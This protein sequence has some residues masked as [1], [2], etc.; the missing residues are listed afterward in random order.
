MKREQWM[1]VV[2]GIFI[3]VSVSLLFLGRR[4]TENMETLICYDQKTIS[5]LGD[6]LLDLCSVMT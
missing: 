3:L 5:G 1:W 4:K 2:V 6:R